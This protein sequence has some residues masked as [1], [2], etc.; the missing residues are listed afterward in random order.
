M[1]E[2]PPLPEAIT[3]LP[4]NQLRRGVAAWKAGHI[5]LKAIDDWFHW[6]YEARAK[7]KANEPYDWPKG[8]EIARAGAS[9]IR[10]LVAIGIN[11]A[12]FSCD[13]DEL[14]FDWPTPPS[15]LFDVNSYVD[16]GTMG[17]F[18]RRLSMI[19][20]LLHPAVRALLDDLASTPF[21]V[22]HI[23]E[24]EPVKG[25][26]E[27]S[28][29]E[30]SA[31]KRNH[32]GAQQVEP[33]AA[34][35]SLAGEPGGRSPA[36]EHF[37]RIDTVKVPLSQCARI[38]DNLRLAASLLRQ[39][40]LSDEVKSVIARTLSP[41]PGQTGELQTLYTVAVNTWIAAK[42]A[43]D[44]DHEHAAGIVKARVGAICGLL[45]TIRKGEHGMTLEELRPLARELEDSAAL[46][47][48]WRRQIT[49]NDGTGGKATDDRTT[50]SFAD[51]A[52]LT[53]GDATNS[54]NG[55]EA[56]DLFRWNGKQ[57][58]L[59]P[60]PWKMVRALWNAAKYKMHEDYLIEA[61]YGLEATGSLE[62]VKANANRK[63]CLGKLDVYISK[64]KEFYT[65]ILPNLN[66]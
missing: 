31:E 11:R 30:K 58:T 26:E 39:T 47:E 65:L 37:L 10:T 57:T 27:D 6:L 34:R 46:L 56:P 64:N 35:F 33:E 29:S 55:P 21:G 9:A 40:G 22:F 15:E 43:G 23:E 12:A 25:G 42:E 48:S 66:V 44:D 54:E 32:T 60:K 20:G 62:T 59:Q 7:F 52:L 16:P 3:E 13:A 28:T 50:L 45:V 5:L 63:N 4:D 17:E 38:I 8:D 41:G 18:D 2:L 51:K 14:L 24:G 61:V 53:V 1:A 19:S 49:P 36:L